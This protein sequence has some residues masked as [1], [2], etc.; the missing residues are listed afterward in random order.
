MLGGPFVLWP[1]YPLLLAGLVGLPNL[2]CFKPDG[3]WNVILYP[4][5]LWL[6]G[7]F[8]YLIFKEKSL[9]AIIGR[10]GFVV[11]ALHASHLCQRCLRAVIHHLHA[12]FFFAAARYLK[13]DSRSML[14][15]DVYLG[16]TRDS[17][18]LF[19]VIL[20]GVGDSS[21]F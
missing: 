10:I 1:L 5:N 20:I 7:W 4:F 8:V 21:F 19:G 13:D 18:T 11:F 12:D 9:Y 2:A 14:V 17:S 3:F 6:C 15:V 16:G